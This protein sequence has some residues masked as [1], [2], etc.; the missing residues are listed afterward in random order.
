[1]YFLRKR[2]VPA[3]EG[4]DNWLSQTFGFKREPKI[5][6]HLQETKCERPSACVKWC[7]LFVFWEL[8]FLISWTPWRLSREWCH[9]KPPWFL[10]LSVDNQIDRCLPYTCSP[11][12]STPKE[13]GPHC[14]SCSPIRLFRPGYFRGRMRHWVF[15]HFS[16]SSRDK[17]VNKKKGKYNALKFPRILTRLIEISCPIFSEIRNL[18]LFYRKQYFPEDQD[19]RKCFQVLFGF[20]CFKGLFIYITLDRLFNKSLLFVPKVKWP[21]LIWFV[22]WGKVGGKICQIPINFLFLSSE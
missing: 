11:R 6:F 5:K 1:M 12:S 20:C 19:E 14:P 10:I 2:L 18:V 22:W 21:Q 16:V 8:H 4:R 7:P 13:I 3:D 17:C 9:I 15:K